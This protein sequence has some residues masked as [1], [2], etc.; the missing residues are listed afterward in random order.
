MSSGTASGSCRGTTGPTP[1]DAGCMVVVTSRDALNGLV[2]G[3]SARRLPLDLLSPEE[4][5]DLLRGMLGAER[6]DSAPESAAK[7]AA[8]CARLP[9]ALRIAAARAAPYPD[10]SIEDLV[11]ELSDD[12]T[13][14]D[15]L[16]LHD[17]DH[18]GLRAV[19]DSSYHR[20]PAELARLFRL[21]GLH[22]GLHICSHAVAALAQLDLPVARGQ[23]Q[24]LANTHLLEPAGRYRYRFH[25][26][27]RTYAVEC[28]EQ[29]DDDIGES[30]SRRLIEWYAY[31]AATSTLT[32]FPA[33]RSHLCFKDGAQ[34]W[35]ELSLTQTK[36][37]SWWEAELGNVSEIARWAATGL[38]EYDRAIRHGYRGLLLRK[39]AGDLHGAVLGPPIHIALARQGQGDH[40]EAIKLCEEALADLHEP[41]QWPADRAEMRTILAVSL[42]AVGDDVRAAEMWRQALPVYEVLDPR[43]AAD[44]RAELEQLISGEEGCAEWVV[45]EAGQDQEGRAGGCGGVGE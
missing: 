29:E 24:A 11:Q 42:R 33:Y 40:A 9:L 31:H 34:G 22:P 10:M 27:L 39:E 25:D 16:T 26:L 43:K 37:Y 17:D 15:Q 3:T 23:L 32:A 20:L 35:P 21:L 2:V 1:A 36:I 45:G 12:H 44:I 7:L 14:L 28:G 6:V 5:V 41:D 18:L 30:A 38:G 19:F 4:A 13:R 8:L